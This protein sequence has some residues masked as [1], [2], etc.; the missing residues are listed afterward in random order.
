MEVWIEEQGH[1]EKEWFTE[2]VYMCNECSAIFSTTDDF[3]AHVIPLVESEK[4][5]MGSY[6][7]I[8]SDP[9]YTGEE[10]W[11]VDVEG[12]YETITIE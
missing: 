4:H 9:I 1:W 5:F 8:S 2:W 6:T 7:Q 12:H 11:I 10:Y 3:Y